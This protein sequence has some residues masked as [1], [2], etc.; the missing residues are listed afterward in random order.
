MATALFMSQCEV[1]RTGCTDPYAKNYDVAADIDDGSCFYAVDPT[2]GNCEADLEGNL[3]VTNQTD[4]ILYLYKDFALI[5]CIPANAEGFIINIPNQ[6]LSICLL[7]IWKAEDVDSQE[8]YDPDINLVYRQWNIA[9]SNTTDSDERANW[10]ITDNDSYTGSGTLNLTYPEEDEYGQE[11]IY[12]VD[13]FLNSKSGAKLASLQPGVYGKKVSVDYGAHYL[14]FRYWYSDPNSTSGEIT[15]LG[16]EQQ[17]EVILNAEHLSADIT[18]PFYYSVIGKYGELK[19]VNQTANAISIYANDALIE[20]IAKIEGSTQGLSII[21]ANDYTTFL[22]PVSTYSVSAKSIDG[23]ETIANFKGIE[24]IQDESAFFNVGINY[25]TISVI[26]GTDETLLLFSR[27]EEYLGAVIKP[28]E[29]SGSVLVPAEYDSIMVMT[30]NKSKYKLIPAQTGYTVTELAIFSNNEIEYISLWSEIGTNH[31]RSPVIG[32]N[33]T[34]TMEARITNAED[35]ILSFEYS[36]SSELDYDKMT[37]TIDGNLL[38]SNASGEIN[39]TDYQVSLTPGTHT[40]KWTYSKDDL[41]SVGSDYAEVRN[42][43][44]Q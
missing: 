42:I 22:I 29:N 26:N 34:T 31:Y 39:W 17:Q 28:G 19:I 32:D 13:V 3:S 5:T 35:V 7:Q 36:V 18:I 25:Q 30:G 38:I 15:E 43:E 33:E 21:P 16:W 12:Q 4:D 24:I 6:E 1:Q 14:F 20:N 11:V 10:L 37:F 27:N 2:S 41:F 40:V 9:L 44:L 23:S 8:P